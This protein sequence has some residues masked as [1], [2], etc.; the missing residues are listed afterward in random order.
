MHALVLLHKLVL[1]L[2]QVLDPILHMHSSP[3]QH[4]IAIL[5]PPLLQR[6]KA[7]QQRVAH[8]RQPG[9]KYGPVRV[10]SPHA[11]HDVTADLVA[12]GM[13]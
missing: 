9:S 6:A 4:S 8:R 12:Q 11:A 5:H 3:L 2:P 1:N 13:S 7:Y 10:S